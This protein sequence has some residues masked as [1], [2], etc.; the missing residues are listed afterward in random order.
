MNE[1]VFLVGILFILLIQGILLWKCLAIEHAMVTESTTVQ[2]GLGNVGSL[3]EEALDLASDF[4][5][6]PPKPNPAVQAISESI[7]QLILSA[8][9]SKVS[10][11]QEHAP[12]EQAHRS[13]PEDVST[14]PEADS[15]PD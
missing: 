10:M 11:A 12:Q 5:S 13:I 14:P 6:G 9:M 15:E 4:F 8:L 3:L 2:T 7:P 1:Y